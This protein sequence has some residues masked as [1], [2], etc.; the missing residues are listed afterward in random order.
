MMRCVLPLSAEGAANYTD[1]EVRKLCMALWKDLAEW[2]GDDPADMTSQVLQ[3]FRAEPHGRAASV[4]ERSNGNVPAEW[5]FIPAVDLL[6]V[7]GEGIVGVTCEGVMADGPIGYRRETYEEARARLNCEG[8]DPEEEEEKERERLRELEKAEDEPAEPARKLLRPTR[9][10]SDAPTKEQFSD[11]DLQPGCRVRLFGLKVT[12][13]VNGMEGT[14]EKWDAK[15]GRW[16]VILKDKS[17]AT[18][19]PDNLEVLDNLQGKNRW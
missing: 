3:L 9:R 8:P 11:S 7:V 19:K 4:L 5:A 15:E 13:S 16:L 10:I 18:V 1:L 2:V 12:K 14:C 17:T 6:L